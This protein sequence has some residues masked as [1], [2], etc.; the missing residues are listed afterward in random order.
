[1]KNIRWIIALLLLV[2]Y[3]SAFGQQTKEQILKNEFKRLQVEMVNDAREIM[4][5]DNPDAIAKLNGND[6][7]G[8][9]NILEADDKAK[10]NVNVNI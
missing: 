1:M 10:E 3:G 7:Y 5:Y 8:F 6:F 4:N 9:Y 2:G